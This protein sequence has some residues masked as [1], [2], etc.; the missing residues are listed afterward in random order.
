[1][2]RCKAKDPYF[3]AAVW[4]DSVEPES[5]LTHEDGACLLL[6]IADG[7]PFHSPNEFEFWLSAAVQKFGFMFRPRTSRPHWLAR[8]TDEESRQMRVIAL[9]FASAMHRTGD[10]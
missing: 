2:C 7:I 9:L 4:A 6:A 8:Q 1:M 3:Q 5:G 10:L